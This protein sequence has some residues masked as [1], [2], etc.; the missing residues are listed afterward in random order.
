[1]STLGLKPELGSLVVVSEVRLLPGM[2]HMQVQGAAE[3]S[4]TLDDFNVT[5]V[6]PQIHPA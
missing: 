2:P 1:M 5:D 4:K 3:A 6:N